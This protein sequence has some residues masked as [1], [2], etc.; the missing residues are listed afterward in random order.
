[1]GRDDDGVASHRAG[2]Y[3]DYVDFVERL[4]AYLGDVTRDLEALIRQAKSTA[5]MARQVGRELSVRARRGR[6]Q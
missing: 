4:P 3:A 2:A 1:M 5:A 6:Q